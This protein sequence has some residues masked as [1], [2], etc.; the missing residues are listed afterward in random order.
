MR[1]L[2]GTLLR[3][4]LLRDISHSTHDVID[5]ETGGAASDLPVRRVRNGHVHEARSVPLRETPLG[6]IK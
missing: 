4:D 3:D 2:D 6:G 5:L 1:G